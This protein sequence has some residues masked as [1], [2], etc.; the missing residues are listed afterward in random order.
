MVQILTMDPK[1]LPVRDERV[2]R[3]LD[4]KSSLQPSILIPESTPLLG[5]PIST[6][7]ASQPKLLKQ[8][9]S[10]GTL[11]K[12]KSEEASS[13]EVPG[14][15]VRYLS[16]RNGWYCGP[17]KKFIEVEYAFVDGVV[18][19]ICM[20]CFLTDLESKGLD[21]GEAEEL[22][23]GMDAIISEMVDGDDASDIGTTG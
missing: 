5:I 8:P 15:E 11:P 12:L 4:G 3:L 17:C 10:N 2:A 22:D 23:G 9:D 21:F 14:S 18:Y 19:P 20:D 7:G 1:D 13:I 16:E 6:V